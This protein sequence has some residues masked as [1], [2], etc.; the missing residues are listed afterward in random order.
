MSQL[1]GYF[2]VLSTG[3]ESGANKTVKRR[4]GRMA[5]STIFIHACPA[6]SPLVYEG[7][8]S[9][10]VTAI[11]GITDFLIAYGY[12]NWHIACRHTRV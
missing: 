9:R 6:D 1:G 12:A 2:I 7:L 3:I 8:A 10:I 11:P 5:E 4:T